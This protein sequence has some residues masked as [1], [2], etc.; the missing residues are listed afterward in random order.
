M[1]EPARS[2]FLLLAI[3]VIGLLLGVAWLYAKGLSARPKPGEMEAQMARFARKL[4]TPRQIRDMKNPVVATPEI[5]TEAR[6]HFADHCASCHGND[7]SGA[8]EMG[9]KM[10]PRAPEMSSPDTQNMT[11]GE[12]YY[13][14]ENGIRLT[15]MPGWGK[16][17]YDDLDTWKLVLFIRQLPHLSREDLLDMENYNPQSPAEMREKSEE[18]NF[19]NEQPQE[20]SKPSHK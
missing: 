18:E 17:G 20:N 5:L 7:G 15:G 4:A 14:I 13:A 9:Q 3:P 12:L 10:Y 11:D 1:K 8:T 16:G 2:I 6:H 19:L